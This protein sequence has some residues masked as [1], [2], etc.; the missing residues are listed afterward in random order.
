MGFL[1]L[2]FEKAVLRVFGLEGQQEAERGPTT[3]APNSVRQAWRI[4][5]SGLANKGLGSSFCRMAVMPRGAANGLRLRALYSIEVR[6]VKEWLAGRARFFCAFAGEIGLAVDLQH[7]LRHW[8][9]RWP[10]QRRDF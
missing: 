2:S 1:R 6:L 7:L 3:S 5:A 9:S 4:R 8:S 10:R